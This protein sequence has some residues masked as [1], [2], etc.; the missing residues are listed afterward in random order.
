M[1]VR[2]N[3]PVDPADDDFELES[4]VTAAEL[5]DLRRWEKA[6]AEAEK[7]VPPSP[8]PQY[9]SQ[10]RSSFIA[11]RPEPTLNRFAIVAII[12]APFAGIGG[13][14]FGHVALLQISKTG[15][16]GSGLAFVALVL[17]Y[18]IVAA[19]IVAFIVSV[20]MQAMPAATG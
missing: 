5:A 13:I 16:R 1:R 10:S 9:L 18:V 4:A 15:D 12:L 8:R 19:L 7:T 20:A 3:A 17:G 11:A 2:K 14:I 6:T